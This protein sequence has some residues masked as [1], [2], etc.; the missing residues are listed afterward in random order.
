[1]GQ[2]DPLVFMSDAS[3]EAGRL[4]SALK[5][6]G[7]NVVD[8]SLGLLVGGCPSKPA[9]SCDVS[10]SVRSNRSE[11]ARRTGS[12]GVD[13]VFFGEAGRTLDELR[14][15]SSTKAA[16]SSCA[17]RCLRSVRKVE[18]LI[19]PPANLAS[20]PPTRTRQ[21]SPRQVQPVTLPRDRS[22]LPASQLAPQNA[23]ARVLLPS[24]PVIS[25][26]PF[27]SNSPPSP[28]PSPLPNRP[29]STPPELSLPRPIPL[30]FSRDADTAGLARHIPQSEMSPELESI[31]AR[32]EQ[33]I[34]AMAGSGSNR[35]P[36]SERMT[37]EEEVD[38]VLPADVLL[39]LDEPLD[40]VDD[41]AEQPEA[42]TGTGRGT[43]TGGR[44]GY[45]VTGS[46]PGTNVGTGAGVMLTV[47]SADGSSG[48]RRRHRGAPIDERRAP[49]MR[50]RPPE[51][52]TGR[53]LLVERGSLR[54]PSRGSIEPSL[55]RIAH[56]ARQLQTTP[57]PPHPRRPAFTCRAPE[58]V[59]A[60]S[61]RHLAASHRVDPFLVSDD[62][63]VH[64]WCAHHGRSHRAGHSTHCP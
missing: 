34:G 4:I 10:A 48:R 30:G 52:P 8:V 31:L 50:S 63:S 61:D 12:S 49:Q 17:R 28:N 6:R 37:P 18:A 24:S 1:M 21:S 29:S 42:G 64:A 25:S 45:G 7:Y 23:R 57:L 53:P 55:R 33:R 19:G 3:A 41:E 5:G 16:A 60:F 39:A 40:D 35:A 43:S 9:G 51:P 14:D 36:Q 59:R 38:A 47:E 62:G 56:R 58:S 54:E 15:G 26:S 27:S 46:G 32:A 13:I 11:V 20:C 44:T 22:E 2:D